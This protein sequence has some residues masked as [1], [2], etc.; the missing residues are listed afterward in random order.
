[1][2][3]SS[4]GS[5]QR[6]HKMTWQETREG[7]QRVTLRKME[8]PNAPFPCPVFPY[9]TSEIICSSVDPSLLT[10][11]QRYVLQSQLETIQALR[12]EL[13]EK[14]DTDLL[15]LHSACQLTFEDGYEQDVLPPVVERDRHSDLPNSLRWVVC[16]GA[17]RVYL[18]RMTCQKVQAILIEGVAVP[19]YAYPIPTPWENLEVINDSDHPGRVPDGYLKKFH[20]FSNHRAYYR[21]FNSAF[22]NVGDSRPRVSG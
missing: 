1:M 19:Y 2:G 20:R 7:I 12:W 3:W 9:R 14:W 10:S 13:L 5:I 18:S 16:D 15:Q 17:H 22:K 6:V 8:E 11:P 4:H 21:D